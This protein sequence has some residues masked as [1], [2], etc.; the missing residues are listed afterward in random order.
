MIFAAFYAIIIIMINIIANIR[1][2]RGLGLRSLKKVT[3]Y[4]ADH[5]IDYTLYV[6]N[7]KGH[8]TQIAHDVSKNGGT[9]IAMGGDGTFHDVLNGIADMENTTVG[10]IPAGKG[11]D[12]TRSAG[13]SLNPIKDLKDI[14][15]GKT[16]KI[17]YIKISDKRCL[18]IA[19]TGL[20]VKVLELAYSKS[21]LTYIGSLIYWIN[22]M[23]P[24]NATV[25]IDDGQPVKYSC[26]MVGVCN[27]KAFGGNIRIC[28]VAEI[29][30]GYIDVIIMQMPQKGNIM[31]LLTKFVKGKHMDMPITTHFRCKKVHIESDADIELDGEIYKNLS[32]DCEI[33]PNG[34]TIY[35][36]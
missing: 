9:V 24:C 1:S 20:D 12:F 10:F 7:Y 23:V 21:G 27:G 28:P 8:A 30:D 36:P 22:H 26:I 3:A 35:T 11:N 2:G 25:T 18:N 16:R 5:S 34:L 19:G 31:K 32:F 15:D 6:T 29:N 17:D 4:L 14:L 13:F 33:V